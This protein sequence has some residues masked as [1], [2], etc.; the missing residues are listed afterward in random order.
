MS[1]RS[2]L[3]GLMSAVLLAGCAT[4]PEASPALQTAV[5]ITLD[6]PA[7]DSMR[8][9]YGSG[10]AAG[11]SI[12]AWRQLADYTVTIT[13]LR[14]VPQAVVMGLDGEVRQP[15]CVIDGRAKPFAAIFDVDETLIL[16]AGYEAWLAEGNSYSSATWEEWE[17]TG[18][19]LARPVPGA[20]EG[21]TRLRE[22][23]VTPVFNTNRQY[24]A[25]GAAAA[26]AAAGLGEA[27][28]G[29]TL[30]LR[31][32]DGTNSGGKDA[33]RAMIA[34][35]YCVIALAGD[36]LGDFADV[37]NADG[38]GVQERRALAAS[39]DYAR[40]WGNGWFLLPNPVYG[41]S[42]T[43]SIGEVFP[44]DQRWAPAATTQN[45]R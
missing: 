5:P 42:I 16:N 11:V 8:W 19:P 33:R 2:S 44:A 26:I 32:D 4:V 10:E 24:S 35:K 28:H 17:R 12:Q 36:N 39:G 27:V 6:S 3:T 37:F 31:G 18:A 29:E 1:V 25:E 38:L 41:D 15:A 9:L 22:A 43:G 45:R 7:P 21:L 13:R 20:A 40:L 34:E 30:Y 23:G 14:R